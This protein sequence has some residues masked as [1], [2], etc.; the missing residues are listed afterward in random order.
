MSAQSRALLKTWFETGDTPTQAQFADLL[1]SYVS[2]NDDLNT[3]GTILFE[4]VTAQV[5][6]L[7]TLNSAP[8][9]I[10]AAPGAGKYIR[11]ISLEARMVFQAVAYVNNL[12]PK[13]AIDTADDPLFNFQLNWMGNTMD[14]FIQLSKQAGLPD[15]NQFVENKSLQLINTVGDSINGDSLLE[16]FVLYQIISA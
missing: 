11:V 14:S 15:R 2:I 13:I 6:E 16:L 10:I 3:S 9:E 4:A 1:D 5:A 7:K 8:F 12:T